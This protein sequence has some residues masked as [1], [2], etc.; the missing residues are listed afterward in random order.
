MIRPTSREI[1]VKPVVGNIAGKTGL[2]SVGL[3]WRNTRISLRNQTR[4][5]ASLERMRGTRWIL[6]MSMPRQR[7]KERELVIKREDFGYF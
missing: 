5:R 3:A 1:D 2:L 7:E 6:W 4:Y